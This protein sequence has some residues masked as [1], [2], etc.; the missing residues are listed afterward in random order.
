MLH[1]QVHLIS[2]S[3][4]SCPSLPTSTYTHHSPGRAGLP[5]GLLQ[6]P[7]YPPVLG[8]SPYSCAQARML[9]FMFDGFSKSP[10]PPG[11]NSNPPL[12]APWSAQ[13]FPLT[14][15]LR[16][17]E[18][19]C[20]SLPDSIQSRCALPCSPELFLWVFLTWHRLPCFSFP[21]LLNQTPDFSQVYICG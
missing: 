14:S 1:I 5:T 15:T 6:Y 10:P 2:P 18:Q 21:P 17:P 11:R 12:E 19:S 9:P 13:A 3:P 7:P 4:Q 20:T 8:P 16:S